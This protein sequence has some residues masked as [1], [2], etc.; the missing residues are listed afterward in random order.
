MLLFKPGD[1]VKSK[2]EGGYIGV[3]V[4]YDGEYPH[5]GYS[6]RILVPGKEL[7]MSPSKFIAPQYREF[8]EVIYDADGFLEPYTHEQ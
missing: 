1:I 8:G 3:I 7:P 6:V 2:I 5:D 4:D